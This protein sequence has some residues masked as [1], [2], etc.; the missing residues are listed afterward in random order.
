VLDP[1]TTQGSQSTERWSLILNS[2]PLIRCSSI[3]SCL[4][5]PCRPGQKIHHQYWVRRISRV[6]KRMS[7]I[8]K[9]D[10]IRRVR[11][12][13]RKHRICFHTASKMSR[14]SRRMK[15]AKAC[16]IRRRRSQ[17][18]Q[19]EHCRRAYGSWYSTHSLEQNHQ[20]D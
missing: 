7:R 3:S 13:K 19:D 16:R 8:R 18:W 1:F 10:V 6:I 9:V 20:H 17:E 2:N 15:C 4:A 11:I 12:I 5:G 14:E